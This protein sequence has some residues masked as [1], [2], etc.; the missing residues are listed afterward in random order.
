MNTRTLF[1]PLITMM[2]GAAIA[3]DETRFMTLE[4]LS[5]VSTS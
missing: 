5:R 4:M 2:S 3:A 1:I